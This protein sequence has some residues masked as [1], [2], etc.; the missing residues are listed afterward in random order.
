MNAD[1]AARRSG[2]NPQASKAGG[3]RAPL[4]IGLGCLRSVE[5]DSLVR[6][7]GPK[8]SE[9]LSRSADPYQGRCRHLRAGELA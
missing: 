1:P 5:F 6:R 7:S 2:K 9:L 4:R 8:G 3:P